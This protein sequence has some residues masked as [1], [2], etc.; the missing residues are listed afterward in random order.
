MTWECDDS[1]RFWPAQKGDGLLFVSHKYHCV[2][3]ISKGTRYSLV[4]EL[5]PKEANTTNRM[6]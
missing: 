2:K 1:L 6:F 5:W 4:I 3:T